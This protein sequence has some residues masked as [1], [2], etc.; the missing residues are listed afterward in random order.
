MAR[1]L[2]RQMDLVVRESGVARFDPCV[3]WRREV[4]PAALETVTCG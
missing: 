2:N 3:V 4:G 1:S